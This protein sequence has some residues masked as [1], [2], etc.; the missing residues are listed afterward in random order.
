VLNLK[1]KYDHITI[2]HAAKD[3]QST[4]PTGFRSNEIKDKYED[5]L[6][7]QNVEYDLCF[8]PRKGRPVLGVL[9]NY[10][11]RN[12]T[13]IPDFVV[14]G[15]S[16][17]KEI[18]N[19]RMTLGSNTESFMKTLHV[20]CIIAKTVCSSDSRRWFMAV[21]GSKYSDRGLDII[22]Q[23]VKS[24]DSLVCFYVSSPDEDQEVVMSIKGHYEDE[25]SDYAP[26]DSSFVLIEK[27][28]GV[29]LEDAIATYVND[30]N[31]DFFAI[32]PRAQ[33]RFTTL[34][35]KLMVDVTCSIVLCK[36]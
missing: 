27:E 29:S 12:T 14:M 3:D 32:A 28:R 17:W 5:D 20:P 13:H 19:T 22:L 6:R 2:F 7:Y 8:E 15:H 9:Q 36:N 10:I 24:R 26:V 31:P 11:D 35:S 34:T 33:Q 4:I 25:L 30:Q 21:D 1:R 16:G 18:E 23:M